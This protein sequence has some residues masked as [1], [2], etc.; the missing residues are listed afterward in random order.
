MLAPLEQFKLVALLPLNLL[1]IDFSITNILIMS[2]IFLVSFISFLFFFK[3]Y[4]ISSNFFYFYHIPNLTQSFMEILNKTSIQLVYS[5][6][7][8]NGENFYPY[9]SSLF[10]FI[11]F[12]NLVG[13]IPYT[14]TLTSHLL[15]TFFLSFSIFIGVNVIG[16]EKHDFAL[17]SL[18]IPAN[19]SLILALVLVPIEF[20]SYLSKPI[21]LGVRLFINIMAGHTLLKVILGFSWS[22][23]LIDGLFYFIL[24]F[25]PLCLLVVLMGLELGVALIQAY[26]FTILTCIYLND[27]IN[28]H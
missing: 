2:F 18:I 26:V 17:F 24:H 15:I 4:K 14:F 1:T 28:L 21:S 10:L 25:I 9:V 19:S 23:L 13:L 6:L 5:N 7:N 22:L 27:S 11:L 16:F 8:K 12:S 3:S 20:V